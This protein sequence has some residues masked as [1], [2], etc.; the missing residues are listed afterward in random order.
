MRK[1]NNLLKY[2]F[3]IL[4][5]S[6]VY[7]QQTS[8]NIPQLFNATTQTPFVI[9][10]IGSGTA[11]YIMSWN[12]QGTISACSIQVD[13]SING[14][15]GWGNGDVIAAQTCTGSGQFA[16]TSSPGVKNFVRINPN[17]TI[18]G[19]GTV[20]VTLTGYAN[21]PASIVPFL[22]PNPWFD[23][24]NTAGCN[25]LGN[26]NGVTGN[27]NDD[28]PAIANCI[29]SHGQ[30]TYFL[31]CG[32]SP[33]TRY[34]RWAT[35]QVIN[36]G[37]WK[38]QACGSNNSQD[39]AGAVAVE[40]VVDMAAGTAP[41]L[42]IGNVG[43]NMQEGPTIDKSVHWRDIGNPVAGGHSPG[44]AITLINVANSNISGG[45]GR[46]LS[47]PLSAPTLP[48]TI[49]SCA[50][51]VGG[52]INSNVTVFVQYQ[53]VYPTYNESLP[54]GEGSFNTLTAGCGA[55]PCVCTF[56]APQSIPTN[57]IGTSVYAFLSS[58][59]ERRIGL[60]FANNVAA[61][62]AFTTNLVEG[63]TN[64]AASPVTTIPSSGP[65]VVNVYNHTGGAW[66]SEVSTTQI[67]NCGF[68]G[69]TCV[70]ANSNRNTIKNLDTGAGQGNT[71]DISIETSIPWVTINDWQQ[72]SGNCPN[73]AGACFGL[74][75]DSPMAITVGHMDGPSTAG[76]SV[77]LSL[78]GSSQV[79][80]IDFE[81]GN[82]AATHVQCTTCKGAMMFL[83]FA[84]VGGTGNPGYCFAED[85]TSTQNIIWLDNS[86]QSGCKF[87]IL[88]S[89][90][91]CFTNGPGYC[92]IQS[93]TL[94]S[95]AGTGA[96]AT[97]TP[98]QGG[99]YSG[100][101]RC[102]GTTGASTV[103]LTLPTAKN[104]YSCYASDVTS[105]TVIPQNLSTTTTCRI[106]A[107]SVTTNDVIN[108]I[109]TPF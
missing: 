6:F 39:N 74:V 20:T 70:T 3:L 34:Y 13:S 8:Q 105:G 59:N 18:T 98:Q 42:T 22:G 11:W 78:V 51:N 83:K 24:T 64:T 5:S 79:F 80:G 9:N 85:S 44:G 55:S 33:T 52:T 4:L 86:S 63:G 50:N 56:N 75:A 54:S 26:S 102:T 87:N 21:N 104:G 37:G 36:V 72:N 49:A 16:V 73:T 109:A 58:G 62:A 96:C 28:A 100:A 57:A 2:L 23:V 76:A 35:S 107:A 101:F 29:N 66:L 1:V 103:T 17:S 12:V 97:I 95:L 93:G 61:N 31:P 67:P 65:L 19:T 15:S 88:G 32:N 43:L 81:S 84:G 82:A 30:G 68:H 47:D 99:T 45:G 41:A 53:F 7:G 89:D 91:P 27:G 40:I 92:N 14:V 108:F 48:A 90:N 77:Q 71:I 25:A 38:L 69:D 94:A 60:P 10:L 46:F 106:N